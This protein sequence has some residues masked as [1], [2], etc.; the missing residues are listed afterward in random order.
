MFYDYIIILKLG[1]DLYRCRLKGEFHEISD[2]KFFSSNQ[3]IC[4]KN[5]MILPRYYNWKKKNSKYSFKRHFC[6]KT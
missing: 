6:H 1:L 5:V 4:M 3:S 2:L